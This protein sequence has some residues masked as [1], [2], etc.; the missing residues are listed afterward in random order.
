M[1]DWKQCVPGF[2]DAKKPLVLWKVQTPGPALSPHEHQV[3]WTSS[4]G[5]QE[6]SCSGKM[7]NTGVKWVGAAK[8]HLLLLTKRSSGETKWKLH[9]HH[10]RENESLISWCFNKC[11]NLEYHRTRGCH[12]CLLEGASTAPSILDHWIDGEKAQLMAEMASIESL[13]PQLSNQDLNSYKRRTKGSALPFIL[14][15]VC[16]VLLWKRCIDAR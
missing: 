8:K 6:F 3:N 4:R 12:Q 9:H 13:L 1:S 5:S 14:K 10:P 7:G 11:L 16:C 15:D 2:A